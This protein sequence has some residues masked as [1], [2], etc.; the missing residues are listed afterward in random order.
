MI[1][2]NNFS[3]LESLLNEREEHL[4]SLYEST[5]GKKAVRDLSQIQATSSNTERIRDNGE[6][7]LTAEIPTTNQSA[8]NTAIVS[9]DSVGDSVTSETITDNVTS[10]LQK[11]VQPDLDKLKKRTDKSI[12]MLLRQRVLRESVQQ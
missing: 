9:E 1:E 6:S 11:I 8:S 2:G 4:V 12:K 7:D 10:D 3:V 5:T